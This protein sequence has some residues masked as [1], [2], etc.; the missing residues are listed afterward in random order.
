MKIT[1]NGNQQEIDEG[2][3]LSQLLDQH[4]LATK[5]LAIEINEEIV[6]RTQY[7]RYRLREGDRVEVVQAIG[8]G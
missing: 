1:M 8:G 3:T 5:R 7:T 6:P 2:A 4:R